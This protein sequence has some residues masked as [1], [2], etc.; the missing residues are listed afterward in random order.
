MCSVVVLFFDISTKCKQPFNINETTFV[1]FN[2]SQFQYVIFCQT[3]IV[4]QYGRYM[5]K[6]EDN[7]VSKYF[8]I[9]LIHAV[10]QSSEVASWAIQIIENQ[11]ANEI[12][13]IVFVVDRIA[14][15]FENGI[16]RDLVDKVKDDLKALFHL[17]VYHVLIGILSHRFIYSISNLFLHIH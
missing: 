16:I 8:I 14:D 12:N 11:Y 4:K 15:M 9:K 6:N 5:L 17:F 13:S 2:C 3:R 1:S 10:R 7:N